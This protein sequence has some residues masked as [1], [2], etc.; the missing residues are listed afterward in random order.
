MDFFSQLYAAFKE[1]PA[2]ALLVVALIAIV[3]LAKALLTSFTA[4]LEDIRKANAEHLATAMMVAPLAS[5][6][7]DCVELV[8]RV[9]S[10]R[11]GG[12]S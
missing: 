1:N 2:V 4:R 5:K 9:A 11:Q 6:L 7:V 12:T 3:W 10:G 8:E